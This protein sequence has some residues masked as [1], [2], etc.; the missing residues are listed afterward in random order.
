MKR[1]FLFLVLTICTVLNINSAPLKELQHLDSMLVRKPGL[2]RQKETA[3]SRLRY[4]FFSSRNNHYRLVVCR[5]LVNQ[6]IYFQYDSAK[7]YAGRGLLIA[8]QMNR[9]EDI[10]F[11]KIYKARILSTGGIYDAALRLMNEVNENT[12]TFTNQRE[13]CITMTDLYRRWAFYCKDD[14]YTPKYF[15]ESRRWLTKLMSYISKDD[16]A[17]NFYQ[18]KYLMEVEGNIELANEY[19][20]KTI[21]RMPA[22]ERYYARACFSYARNLWD[23]GN[24]NAAIRYMAMSASGDIAACTLDNS[25]S[26]AL[27]DFLITDDPENSILAEKYI[28]VALNDAKSYNNRLRLVEISQSLI[29]ILTAYKAQLSHKEHIRFY[30]LIGSMCFIITLL[31]A[32]WLILRQYK[33]L[34]KNKAAMDRYNHQLAGLNSKLANLNERL[35]STNRY[36][37]NLAAI[38]IHLCSKYIEKLKAQRTLVLRKL[39]TRQFDDLLQRLQSDRISNEETSHFLNNFDHAFLELYPTF[40]EEFSELLL[41]EYRTKNRD[42]A[43][44]T[45]TER[46]AALCRLGVNDTSET[47]NLLFASTQS[48]YN[49]KSELRNK[50]L[51]K[52]TL[53]DDIKGLCHVMEG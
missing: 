35:L 3:I 26:K 13:Y 31:L 23:A 30:V 17:Y 44:L 36:R 50:A 6:Y 28:N 14:E 42:V 52:E 48:I 7:A 5:K 20:L 47:A 22:S 12:L 40:R 21:R 33:T 45:T 46:I 53:W 39:K 49:R 25:A 9:A 10:N 18:A 19:F 38:Y 34:K 1:T 29:P 51:N 24:S 27:A 37:E 11:F 41:P 43:S 2:I 15:S 16:S 8:Q 32:G 4:R